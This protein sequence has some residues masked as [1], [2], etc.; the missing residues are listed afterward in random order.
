MNGLQHQTASDEEQKKDKARTMENIRKVY[1]Q[2]VESARGL[3][4]RARAF[5]IR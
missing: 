5:A 4:E 1:D 3:Y 2:T